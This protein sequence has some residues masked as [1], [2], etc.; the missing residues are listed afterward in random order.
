MAGVAPGFQHPKS[1]ALIGEDIDAAVPKFETTRGFEG[2]GKGVTKQS[3]QNPDVSN[4]HNRLSHVLLR[5]L[6]KTTDVALDLLSHALTAGDDIVRAEGGV[7]L[8]R[9]GISSPDLFSV[10]ALE[11]AEVPFPQ[12][13]VDDDPVTG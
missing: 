8:V 4:H 10:Q 2:D 3:A 9:V 6:F 12:A 7:Q 5:K 11:D 13:L 1:L